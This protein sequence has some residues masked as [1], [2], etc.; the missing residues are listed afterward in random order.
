MKTEQVAQFLN[1]ITRWASTQGDILALALVGSYAREAATET[2]D[3]DLVIIALDPQRYLENTDWIR[4]FGMVEKQQAE[5]YGVL[6]SVRVWYRDRS[7]IEY[8][9]TDERW[10]ALPLDEGTRQV[11]AGGMRVLFE[12]GDILSRHLPG[13]KNGT[14]SS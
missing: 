6:T 2:S 1:V 13:G 4:R 12:R 8:G 14:G 10:S 11:I 5:D 9:L 7:E 3:V